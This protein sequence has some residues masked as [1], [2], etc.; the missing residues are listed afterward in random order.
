MV[1]ASERSHGK[2]GRWICRQSKFEDF[3]TKKPLSLRLKAQK[4]KWL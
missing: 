3:R 4:P 1:R 2:L